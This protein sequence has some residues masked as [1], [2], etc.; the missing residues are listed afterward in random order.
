MR[1]WEKLEQVLLNRKALLLFATANI[2]GTVFGFYYYADQL[3][4]NPVILWP[5]IPD[6]PIATLL[7]AASFLLIAYRRDRE[8]VNA[9]AV[10]GNLKY[11]L[12][13]VFVLTYYSEIFYAGNTL[14]MYLF[15]LL[16]HVGM[17]VQALFLMEISEVEL[18]PLII[19]AAWFIVNDLV[20]YS[21]GIHTEIYTS[22]V[23]PAMVAAFTLTAGA[24]TLL[25]LRDSG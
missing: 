17:A 18:R 3:S 5:F 15:L 16:S 7:A 25:Y 21:L 23:F 22:Q 20:D 6:S 12:W 19:A 1:Y 8:L 14:P 11:G 10:I 2:L 9:F 4:A 24:I 13:T